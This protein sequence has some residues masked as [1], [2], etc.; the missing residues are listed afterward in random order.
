MTDTGFL[1]WGSGVSLVKVH[2]CDFCGTKSQFSPTT[3][4]AGLFCLRCRCSFC[5]GLMAFA[6]DE[7]G[8]LRTYCPEC[9]RRGIGADAVTH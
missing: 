8:K 4:D 1:A 7:H 2:T 9:E 6:T 3:P 5:L